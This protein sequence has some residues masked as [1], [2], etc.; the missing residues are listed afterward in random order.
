[1]SLVIQRCPNCGSVQDEGGVC[2][3][4]HDAD[5]RWFCPN[6]EPGRWLDAA[7][8]GACGA[9]AT[10]GPRI[11]PAGPSRSA[12]PRSA[13]PPRTRPTV[14]PP[15]PPSPRTPPVRREPSYSPPV[16]PSWPEEPPRRRRPRLPEWAELPTEGPPGLPIDPAVLG[17]RVRAG[18]PA[19][20]GCVGRLVFLVLFI[21]A[22]LAAAFSYVVWY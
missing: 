16:E 9:T 11:A 17:S 7:S 13:P 21:L 5:V 22:L 20:A 19:V 14:P 2:T 15:I 4:C 18:L 1:M 10:A 12:P 3:V 8:C 6:H